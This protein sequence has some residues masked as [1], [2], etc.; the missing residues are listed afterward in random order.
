MKVIYSGNVVWKVVMEFMIK[1][2]KKMI[3][4]L[5]EKFYNRCWKYI[6]D[7]KIL[8]YIVLFIVIVLQICVIVVEQNQLISFYSSFR[9]S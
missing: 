4:I 6:I 2:V 7:K 3:E 9:L 1:V 5:V 8:R